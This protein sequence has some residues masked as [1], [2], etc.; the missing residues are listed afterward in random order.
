MDTRLAIAGWNDSST[1][2]ADGLPAQVRTRFAAIAEA[3]DPG[4]VLARSTVLGSD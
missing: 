4:R 1:Q 2:V 3:L